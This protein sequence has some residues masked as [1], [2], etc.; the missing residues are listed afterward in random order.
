MKNKDDMYKLM[1]K[2]DNIVKRVISRVTNTEGSRTLHFIDGE[3]SHSLMVKMRNE[4][5]V[6][7]QRVVCTGDCKVFHQHVGMTS[8]NLSKLLASFI[9]FVPKAVVRRRFLGT[10]CNDIHNT[11]NM[12]KV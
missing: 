6:V 9:F 4:T 12:Y 5:A 11:G 1:N 2:A 8:K 10:W 3:L 7:R